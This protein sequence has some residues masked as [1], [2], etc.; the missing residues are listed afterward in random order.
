MAYACEHR[1]LGNQYPKSGI[2]PNRETRVSSWLLLAAMA[3]SRQTLDL[4]MME[5]LYIET[6]Y[7]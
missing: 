2:V 6:V 4:A 7:I 1:R 5:I 3:T